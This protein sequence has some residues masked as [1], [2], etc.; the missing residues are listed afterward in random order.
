VKIAIFLFDGIT[1]LDAIGPYESLARLPDARIIFVAK[2]VGPIRTGNG[3][4]G[5]Y[6]DADIATERDADVL[7]VPGGNHRGLVTAIADK[8]VHSWICG[9]DASS[10]WT[11]SVCTGS[12]ILAAAGILSGRKAATHWRAKEALSK[13]GV[14][15]T[16]ARVSIDGK[17]MTSAGVSAGLDMG[18]ALCAELAG[19]EVAEAVQLSMQYDPQPPFDTGNPAKAATPERVRMIENLLR[20]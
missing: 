4:L 9:I 19:R 18:L 12:L 8:E 2:T 20:S 11:C 14:Q 13:F 7:I 5:L 6:A 10:R 17:Y 3:F 16:D 1:A 15:Y